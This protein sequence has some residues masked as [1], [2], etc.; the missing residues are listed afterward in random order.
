MKLWKKTKNYLVI[1]EEGTDAGFQVSLNNYK[2]QIIIVIY[3]KNNNFNFQQIVTEARD[4]IL[5]LSN[6]NTKD[7]KSKETHVFAPVRYLNIISFLII[8]RHFN[9]IFLFEIIFTLK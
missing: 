3:L 5:H 7:G 1:V 4:F 2:Y 8:F 9:I 6:L